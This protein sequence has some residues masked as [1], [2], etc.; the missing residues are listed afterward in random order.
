VPARSRLAARILGLVVPDDNPANHVDGIITTGALLAAESTRHESLLEAAGAV[1]AVI[2]AVWL[3]HSYSAA[4]AE[5]LQSGRPWSAHQLR[6]TA[7]HELALLQGAI[8]P[9]IVLIVADLAGLSV[10]QAVIAALASAVALL[11]TFEVVAGTRG[12]LRAW[13][14]AVQVGLCVLIG[15]A[16][17]ALEII[18]H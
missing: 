15:G 14:L 11:F 2:V 13:E 17:L 4:L 1:T 18:L 5:R 3:S 12:Q 7:A 16:I 8:V 6:H 9:L 10:G